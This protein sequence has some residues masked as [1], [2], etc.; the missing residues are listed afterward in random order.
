MMKKIICLLLICLFLTPTFTACSK[1]PEYAEIEARFKELVEASYEINEV[2]FGKGLPTYQRIYD[3]LSSVKVHTVTDPDDPENVTRTYYYELKDETYGRVVAFRTSYLA[4]YAYVQVLEQE[5]PSRTPYYVDQGAEAFC[6]LL[7]GYTEP[8]YEFFYDDDDPYEYDYV[9][10]DC[11]Y[12]TVSEIKE[13]AQTVY[14]P[15]YLNAI[16]EWLFV[17]TV[18]VTESVD[19]LSARYIEYSDDEGSVYL[20]KSNTFEPLITER[21]LYDF[22]TAKMVK[23][24]NK[25]YV[26]IEI[27]SYLESKPSEILRVRLSLQRVN[28][29][30]MLDSATY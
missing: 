27:D 18:A 2:I 12:F 28:N 1:P 13:L 30:W 24:S 25:N 22:S 8:E 6:Y 19:G 5:D 17:G 9:R 20:M 29:V 14:T 11:G 4:P 26:N 3:P 10:M 23:P 16:Y 7:E 15:E 21:R